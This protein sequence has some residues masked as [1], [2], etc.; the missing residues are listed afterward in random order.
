MVSSK[1]IVLSFHPVVYCFFVVYC[2]VFIKR[3]VIFSN[4]EKFPVLI[5]SDKDFSCFHTSGRRMA[6]IGSISYERL[7]QRI[8]RTHLQGTCTSV[9]MLAFKKDEYKP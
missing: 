4:F 9:V 7:C 6:V 3:N 2:K 8:P 5:S 1:K